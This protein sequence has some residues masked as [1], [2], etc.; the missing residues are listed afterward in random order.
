M[1]VSTG[2]G[3]AGA[4]VDVGASVGVGVGAEVG[5]GV[6]VEVLVGVAAGMVVGAGVGVGVDVGVAVTTTVTICGASPPQDA[7]IVAMV[8]NTA[9]ARR[10]LGNIPFASL[11][12][13]RRAFRVGE[14]VV[15]AQGPVD[16]LDQGAAV[17]GA[18]EAVVAAGNR[19]ACQ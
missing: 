19:A 16:C 4:S 12:Q 15:V 10:F 9:N 5:A 17:V 2:V 13:L 14:G 8:I 6:G 7:S 11:I 1:A 18:A 3:G